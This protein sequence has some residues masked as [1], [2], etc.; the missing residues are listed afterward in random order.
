[1]PNAKT[2]C[3]FPAF[4]SGGKSKRNH[5]FSGPVQIWVSLP[6]GW[7]FAESILWTRSGPLTLF[8]SGQRL[9]QLSLQIPRVFPREKQGKEDL[10]SR[11]F[12]RKTK[13]S[14]PRRNSR[15]PNLQ[16]YVFVIGYFRPKRVGMLMGKVGKKCEV[17]SFSARF[18]RPRFSAALTKPES[19]RVEQNNK[20]NLIFFF[21]LQKIF[22]RVFCGQKQCFHVFFEIRR[23]LLIRKGLSFPR[24]HEKFEQKHVKKL[25]FKVL[26]LFAQI[27]FS[28]E[29][30]LIQSSSL[31][32]DGSSAAMDS[33]EKG[34]P[35]LKVSAKHP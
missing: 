31:P 26:L 13:S 5:L 35:N 27:L 8:T 22:S 15:N 17:I 19:T 28:A 34:F 10:E 33:R 16:F 23:R 29:S 20:Q 3:Q 12:E 4:L 21:P 1:M 11:R 25:S 32:L 14:G 6:D 30:F 24:L 7:K 2:F 18:P 9:I